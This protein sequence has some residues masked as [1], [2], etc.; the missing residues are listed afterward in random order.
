MEDLP[1]L[2]NGTEFASK[3]LKNGVVLMD[4]N[5]IARVFIK[6]HVCSPFAVSVERQADGRLRY[7]H[8]LMTP[9]DR[10]CGLAGLDRRTSERIMLEGLATA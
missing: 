7:M 10:W 5:G 4:A 2:L 3:S 6:R 9:D 1:M 8:A